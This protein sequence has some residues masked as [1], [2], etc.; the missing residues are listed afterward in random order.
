MVGLVQISRSLCQIQYFQK[1][2][3]YNSNLFIFK[4]D[5]IQIEIKN[6]VSKKKVAL[7]MQK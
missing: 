5:R 3:N 7:T 4:Q 1:T 6:I 2:F